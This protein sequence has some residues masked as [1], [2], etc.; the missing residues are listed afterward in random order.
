MDRE[1]RFA[2][3]GAGKI[4]EKFCEAVGLL[5][6]ARVE[7]VASRSKERADA[8]AAGKGI[9]RAYGSYEEMLQ[10]GNI[11]CVYISA[12]M[13]AHYRLAML[14]LDYQVPFLCEKAA[15]LTQAEATEVFSRCR[16]LNVFGMEA[17][18]SRFLPSNQAAKK[19]L[20]SGT[21]GKP[22][23][24]NFGLGFR[25]PKD[26][27]NRYFSPALGGGVSY[28]LTVYA[29]ELLTFFLEA[30]AEQYSIQTIWGGGG[31]DVACNILIQFPGCLARLQSTFLADIQEDWVIHTDKGAL[32]MPHAQ[33]GSSWRFEPAEGGTPVC[34]Q[35][36][37]TQNGFVYEL[38]EVMTCVQAG[39]IESSIAP[40]SMTIDSAKLYERVWEGKDTG[41]IK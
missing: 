14:C 25:A 12:T 5:E 39:K 21:I 18:W 38:K 4:A 19:L 15:F 13:E 16:E 32:V 3:M 28:D 35:D 29:Y 7:A 8:F 33:S 40:H 20:T 31:V 30:P 24:V 37:Q 23:L 9:K 10:A 22:Q 26:H 11:D 27:Q 1:F 6:G 2:I 41:R 17:M 36:T 34:Y